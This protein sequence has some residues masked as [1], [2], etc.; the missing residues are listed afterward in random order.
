V[1]VIER[2]GLYLNLSLTAKPRLTLMARKY[3]KLKSA[4][5]DK[6]RTDRIEY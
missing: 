1:K 6:I 5:L 4:Y 3:N 2:L